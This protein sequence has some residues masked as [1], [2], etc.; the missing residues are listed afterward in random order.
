MGILGVL[1][2]RIQG[3]ELSLKFSLEAFGI[4]SLLRNPAF[5]PLRTSQKR[6]GKTL[7]PSFP[8]F[9]Q[10]QERRPSA[11]LTFHSFFSLP[12]FLFY[13]EEFVPDLLPLHCTGTCTRSVWGGSREMTSFGHLFYLYFCF[14]I[15]QV[16]F[17][18]RRYAMG[19]V[20][21]RKRG[22]RVSRNAIGS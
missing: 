3:K 16:F 19:W 12:S 5:P 14:S 7:A 11:P 15:S 10:P 20:S 13:V 4:C 18:D 1:P 17:F 2:W 22:C 8:L 9:S 6:K 21:A